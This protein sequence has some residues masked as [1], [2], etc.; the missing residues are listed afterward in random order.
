M[1]RVLFGLHLL[2][3]PV[4]VA[5]LEALL[6]HLANARAKPLGVGDGVFSPSAPATLGQPVLDVRGCNDYDLCF[7]EID[8]LTDH[9]ITA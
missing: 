4:C 3:D 1:C 6:N 7:I 8:N 9:N 2:D 5:P